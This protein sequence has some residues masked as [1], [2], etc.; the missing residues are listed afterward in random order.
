MGQSRAVMTSLLGSGPPGGHC[1]EA[2]GEQVKLVPLEA[3]AGHEAPLV[4]YQPHFQ[5]VLS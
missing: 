1:G 4:V 3:G 2:L 5:T